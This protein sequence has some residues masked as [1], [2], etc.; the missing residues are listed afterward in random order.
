MDINQS[1]HT[2]EERWIPVVGYE[3]L[4]EVSDRGNVRSLKRPRKT[5]LTQHGK[6]LVLTWFEGRVLSPS[7]DKD[8]YL[9]VSLSKNGKSKVFRVHRLV[10]ESFVGAC[11]D[12]M[13][14][15]HWND[16]PDD[17]RLENLRW[18]TSASNGKDKRRNHDGK[19]SPAFCQNGHEMTGYNVIRCGEEKRATRCRLCERVRWRE[20]ARRKRESFQA[21]NRA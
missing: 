12:G 1:T 5:Y 17:N 16:V 19:P 10:L 6:E 14:C 15:C 3:G 2:T 18:G 21:L 13:E 7:A 9:K 20:K 11:P 8:G 4:Y